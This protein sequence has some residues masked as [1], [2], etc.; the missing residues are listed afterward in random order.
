M[1]TET[2]PN[3]HNKG[4][5]YNFIAQFLAFSMYKA[6]C[7]KKLGERQSFNVPIFD[8]LKEKVKEGKN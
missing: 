4:M 3:D 1:L 6:N 8:K 7:P 2:W 5:L